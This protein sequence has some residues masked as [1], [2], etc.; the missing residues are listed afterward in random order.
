[1]TIRLYILYP[2][3]F[4]DKSMCLTNKSRKFKSFEDVTT[5]SLAWSIKKSTI[6]LLTFPN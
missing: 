3:P 6:K 5:F 1:M 2:S 4:H